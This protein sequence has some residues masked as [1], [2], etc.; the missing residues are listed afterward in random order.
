MRRDF[1]DL[2]K[3]Q[4]GFDPEPVHK[5]ILTNRDFNKAKLTLFRLFL[6]VESE[7][8]ITDPSALSG[9]GMSVVEVTSAC[10]STI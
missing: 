3:F 5:L 8:P 4:L 7:L 10:F 2:W 9:L 6:A 1:D